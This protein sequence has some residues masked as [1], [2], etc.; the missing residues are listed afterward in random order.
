MQMLSDEISLSRR[1]VDS[2]RVLMDVDAK[3]PRCAAS[4][5]AACKNL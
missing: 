5:S 1:A 4:A 2:S 3:L